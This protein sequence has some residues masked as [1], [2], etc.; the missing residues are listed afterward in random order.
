MG[1][2]GRPSPP[3]WVVVRNVG[4]VGS[5]WVRQPFQSGELAPALSQAQVVATGN[6]LASGSGRLVKPVLVATPSRPFGR[7]VRRNG[8]HLVR[9]PL[10]SARGSRRCDAVAEPGVHEHSIER[11]APR[12]V[13][14]PWLMATV[15]VWLC[16]WARLRPWSG[17]SNI[18]R[19][20]FHAQHHFASSSKAVVA[21][22]H[23]GNHRDRRAASS[24]SS[25]SAAQ[26]PAAAD[27]LSCSAQGRRRSCRAGVGP[28]VVRADRRPVGQRL[29]ASRVDAELDQEVGIRPNRHPVSS[30]TVRCYRQASPAALRSQ[31]GCVTRRRSPRRGPSS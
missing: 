2:L 25:S 31:R 7:G 19:F 11:T 12:S 13:R 1:L 20:P 10:V 23:A 15:P 8:V 29:R 18:R 27:R 21:R 28:R 24:R 6:R 22:V 14:S 3:A 16:R 17:R 30:M 5:I 4:A 9:A 26:A